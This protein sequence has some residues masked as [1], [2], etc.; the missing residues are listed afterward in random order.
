MA[1]AAAS[2]ESY[3]SGNSA[4]TPAAFNEANSSKAMASSAGSAPALLMLL[5]F[6]WDQCTAWNS[7]RAYP[8]SIRVSM[9]SQAF[10]SLT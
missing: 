8:T 1:S 3:A 7:S 10:M 9:G 2:A 6:S 4:A 5:A